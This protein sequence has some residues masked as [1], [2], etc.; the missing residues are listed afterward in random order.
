MTPHQR[1][2]FESPLTTE[3]MEIPAERAWQL[4]TRPP[5]A[6]SLVV[7]TSGPYPVWHAV[8]ARGDG[9]DVFVQTTLADVCRRVLTGVGMPETDHGVS[10]GIAYH[11]VRRLTEGEASE[12]RPRVEGT[13]QC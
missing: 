3:V 12:L 8:A 10:D 5:I 4:P 9:D 11:L 1:D 2:A 6:V 13:V 7:D